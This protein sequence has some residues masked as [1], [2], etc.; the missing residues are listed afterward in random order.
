MRCLVLGFVT[1]VLVLQNA[2]TLPSFALLACCAIAA[3][4]LLVLAKL[5]ER[6]SA[7]PLAAGAASASA[8]ILLGYA[9]AALLAHHALAP[10]LAFED[11]GRDLQV[12]GIVD[13]LPARFEQGTRFNFRV[14]H[15]LNPS[16]RVPPLVALS[17]Y[18][19][20]GHTGG[21]GAAPFA[22]L[23]PGQRWQLNVRLQ[24]PHGNAN[25]GVCAS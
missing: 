22:V 17:W 11:E 9:W 21:S 18:A 20:K 3:L 16:A 1:G 10:T 8:G 15:T 13:S 19:G 25:P 2:A 5:H 4:A 12:I 24:R 7:R 6:R 14:E 23:Q